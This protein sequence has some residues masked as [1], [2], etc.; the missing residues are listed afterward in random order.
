MEAIRHAV[1]DIAIEARLGERRGGDHGN[2]HVGGKRQNLDDC[3]GRRTD[4][5]AAERSG[6]G[7]RQTYRNAKQ[8]VLAACQ[9]PDKY[10]RPVERMD[11]SG[12]VD[13]A[14]RKLKGMQ[15]GEK[16]LTAPV[17]TDVTGSHGHVSTVICGDS[18]VEL[19]LLDEESADL[20]CTSPPYYNARREY[21]CYGSYDQYLDFMRS[22]VRKCRRVLADGRFFVVVVSPVLVPRKRRNESSKRL[23]L[24]FDFHRLFVEEG[25][26]FIDDIIWEKP[27]GAGWASGRGRRFAADRN[28][29]QYKAVPVTEY[30]L[31]YRKKSDRL[32]DDLIAAVDP[33]VR[34]A[35][36]IGDGY[37]RTNVWRIPP[38]RSK[39]HPA[40]FPLELAERVVRYYSFVGDTVLDPFAG[41]LTTGLAAQNLGRRFCMIE[42]KREYLLE[43]LP[44]FPN[45]VRKGF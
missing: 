13:G 41:S 28:P 8:V 29:L 16:A 43:R 34:Q 26:E 31:V 33:A 12:K 6:F 2:Q 38:A 7:D 35:S 18:L 30:V 21:A 40:P 1:T 14:Y 44:E 5:V 23:A 36:K 4:E 3:H 9:E 42:Q 20:V 27:S 17:A 45:V 15:R 24:P 22:I 25:F 37:Q 32:I 11:E 39:A 19:D 10:A